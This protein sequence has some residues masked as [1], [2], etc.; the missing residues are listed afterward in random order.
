MK[1][2]LV[3]VKNVKFSVHDFNE[4]AQTRT[5]QCHMVFFD[6]ASKTLDL[7]E[8]HE[9]T[10]RWMATHTNVVSVEIESEES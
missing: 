2:E 8:V 1:S 10:M 3:K 9:G 4:E 7:H 6:A 5:A